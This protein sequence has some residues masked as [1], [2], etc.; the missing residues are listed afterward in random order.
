MTKYRVIIN[1]DRCVGCGISTGQC[2]THAKTLSQLLNQN[3]EGVS[4]GI[5]SE[6]IYDRVKQLAEACPVKA[7]IIERIK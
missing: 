7:I 2:P 6:G 1:R 3:Q 4:V 5:F